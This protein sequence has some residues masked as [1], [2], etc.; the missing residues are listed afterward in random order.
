MSYH[1]LVKETNTEIRISTK[2][3]E[4]PG[5]ECVYLKPHS[6]PL[7]PHRGEIVFEDGRIV[8]VKL[9]FISDGLYFK[10]CHTTD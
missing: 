5:T 1:R 9:M 4:V 8:E 3:M 10:K 2:G 7:K 6:N